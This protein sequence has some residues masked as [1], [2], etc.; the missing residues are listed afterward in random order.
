MFEVVHR[1]EIKQQAEDALLRLETTGVNAIP[2]MNDITVLGIGSLED[3]MD[4]DTPFFKYTEDTVPE[5]PTKSYVIL[6]ID[7]ET[8]NSAQIVTDKFMDAQRG[9]TT[10]KFN[11]A[12]VGKPKKDFRYGLPDL[13]IQVR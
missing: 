4:D 13:G 10:C 9:D 11:A 3:A 6:K 1:A 2:L 8:M 5:I 7:A 12:K